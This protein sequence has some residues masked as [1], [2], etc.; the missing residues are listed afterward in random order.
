M[1]LNY[2]RV[3]VFLA[4]NDTQQKVFDDYVTYFQEKDRVC[5]FQL[6][7]LSLDRNGLPEKWPNVH[8]TSIRSN[9]EVLLR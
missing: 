5:F 2:Y 8:C 7:R 9:E 4:E 6:I 3:V 1:I